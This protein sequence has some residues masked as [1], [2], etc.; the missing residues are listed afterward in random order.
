[1]TN[2]LFDFGKET[3]GDYAVIVIKESE[4][5]DLHHASE[6]WGFQEYSKAFAKFRQ[7]SSFHDWVELRDLNNKHDTLLEVGGLDI[8]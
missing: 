8:D 5:K 1:M 6:E 7:L 4:I 3:I 2:E